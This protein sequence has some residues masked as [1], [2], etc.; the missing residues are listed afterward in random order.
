MHS[1][2][3]AWQALVGR[4]CVGPDLSPPLDPKAGAWL[5]VS[6]SRSDLKNT[7]CTPC[8]TDTWWNNRF[9]LKKKRTPCDWG[10]R[11]LHTL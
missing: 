7:P 11:I 3:V 4:L 2:A 1:F 9:G 6:G 5:R 10:P 8:T